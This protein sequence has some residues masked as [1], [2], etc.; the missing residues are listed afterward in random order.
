MPTTQKMHLDLLECDIVEAFD[1]AWA[2]LKMPMRQT[3][4]GEHHADFPSS[5]GPVVAYHGTTGDNFMDIMSGAGMQN[6]DPNYATIS[7]NPSESATY[8][9]QRSGKARKPHL[10]AFFE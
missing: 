2:L 9:V 8:A 6:P 5:Y 10:F 1:N 3:E 4:L 7:T